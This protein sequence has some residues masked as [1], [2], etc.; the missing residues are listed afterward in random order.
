MARGDYGPEVKAAL[1]EKPTAKSSGRPP[2]RKADPG[3]TPADAARDKQQGI[4]EGSP[5]DLRMDA[6][7]G[8]GP[9]AGAQGP[10]PPAPGGGSPAH[11]AMAASI[12]HAILGS[13]KGG[14]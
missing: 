7:G 8:A 14:Y 4:A 11:A 12:A 9:S 13:G 6:S 5:Q 3:E 10:H 2:P 1:A